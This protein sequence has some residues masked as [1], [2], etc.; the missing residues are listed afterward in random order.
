MQDEVED[1]AVVGKAAQQPASGLS[2]DAVLVSMGS[3]YAVVWK[4]GD[5]Q[6]AVRLQFGRPERD[7]RPAP[8]RRPTDLH[9]RAEVAEPAPARAAVPPS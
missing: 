8:R 7:T 9:R 1:L 3:D 6:Q 2:P 5:V 4:A